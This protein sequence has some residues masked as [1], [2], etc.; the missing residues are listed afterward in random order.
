VAFEGFNIPVILYWATVGIY[1]LAAIHKR[2][3]NRRP[4]TS[5]GKGIA[6]SKKDGQT[7]N[8]LT[9]IVV[10][11]LGRV[12]VLDVADIDWIE[13][14]DYYSR[15]HIGSR[16]YL[17]RETMNKLESQLDPLLFFRTHRC[18]IVN[19]N[20]VEQL[21]R[22]PQAHIIQLR[23]GTELKLSRSRHGQLR[24]ALKRLR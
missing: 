21:R 15:I 9:R 22:S 20:R 14:A 5:V 7:P 8:T 16:S 23:D 24:Q 10:K 17:I 12:S 18:A 19:L 1:D 13:A 6:S 2:R 3:A 11:E 4:A